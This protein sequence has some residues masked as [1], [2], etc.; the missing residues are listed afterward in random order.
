MTGQK[1]LTHNRYQ[2]PKTW[3]YAENIEGEWSAL[4]EVLNRKD[5]AIQSQVFCAL[6]QKFSLL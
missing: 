4:L 1:L 6:I 3:L 5:A 2:F